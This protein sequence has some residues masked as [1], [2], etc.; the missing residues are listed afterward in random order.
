MPGSSHHPPQDEN[1]CIGCKQ[2]V[3]HA[4]GCFRIEPEHGRSRVYAQWLNTEAELQ[5]AI[6]ALPR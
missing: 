2:C 1:T 6:G 3:W 5:S 4:P